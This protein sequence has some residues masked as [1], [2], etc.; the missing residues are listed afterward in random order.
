MATL[1]VN[2][3]LLGAIAVANFVAAMLFLRYWRSSRDRFFLYLVA[4]FLLESVN[5]TAAALQSAT[6]GESAVHY[7]VRLAS[8]LLIVLAI[9]EKNRIRRR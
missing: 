2:A 1:S 5:R 3:F 4:S 7:L 9:W 6:E 8:Y